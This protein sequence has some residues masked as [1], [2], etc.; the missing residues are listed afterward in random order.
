MMEFFLREAYHSASVSQS[1]HSEG[2]QYVQVPL[3][4][5]SSCKMI[6]WRNE[7]SCCLI[8]YDRVG[9]LAIIHYLVC[10]NRLSHIEVDTKTN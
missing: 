9:N 3:G 1:C 10:I 4:V 7:I 6:S 8:P 5:C 2:T